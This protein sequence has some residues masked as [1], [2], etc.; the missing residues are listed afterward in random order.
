M[1]ALIAFALLL[2]L[3]PAHAEVYRWTDDKGVVHYGDKP[4]KEGVKPVE[5]PPLQ[6]Y[7]P[8]ATT[9]P[10]AA[11]EP[12][13]PALPT[14]SSLRIVSPVNDDTLRDAAQSIS[15]TVDAA[16]QPGQGLLFFLDGVQQN[17]VATPSSAWLFENVERGE[18]QLGAAI[19]AA[20]GREIVRAAP[21][22]VHMKPPVRLR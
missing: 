22:T 19:V 3:L 15:M 4:P 12:A 6:T 16:L 1:R 2:N 17:K 11:R 20:D 21:V 5:L 14:K 13:N 9:A 10:A 8:S 7:S 18:H